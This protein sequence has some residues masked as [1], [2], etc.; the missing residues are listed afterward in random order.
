MALQFTQGRRPFSSDPEWLNASADRLP[1]T[2]KALS[3]SGMSNLIVTA[4]EW[5]NPVVVPPD[6]FLVVWLLGKNIPVQL[7]DID[8]S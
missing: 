7:V 1:G 2:S 5:L 8:T 6:L 4:P 3:V